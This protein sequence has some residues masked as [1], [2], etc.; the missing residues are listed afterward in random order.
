MIKV[1]NLVKNYGHA[2][3]LQ[4]VSF[5]VPAGQVLGFLGPNGAGKSTTMKIVTGYL[6]PTAGRVIVDG[7]DAA[8]EA[9]EVRRKVGYLPENNPLY[10]DMRVD[11]YLRFVGEIRGIKGADRRA[12]MDRVVEVCGLSLVYRKGIL[13]LSKGYRQRVGLAQ[14]MIHDPE[15]LILDEPTSGLDPNQIIEIREL[16]RSIAERED[17]T[18][19]LS[20][21]YLQEVE[22]T[23]DRI[24][25]ISQGEIV[26]DGSAEE[27]VSGYPSG[28]LEAQIV[29]P[30]EQVRAQLGEL[31]PDTKIRSGAGQE[32]ATSYEIPVGKH[33]DDRA[34]GA[35]F[36]LVVGNSWKLIELHREAASLETV[37]RALTSSDEAQ[38]SAPPTLPKDAAG[39]ALASGAG[40]EV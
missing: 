28:P 40:K 33:L 8:I 26:A 38:R 11:D 20:T 32:G 36:D 34:R 21:H 18:V 17:R 29:G 4:D 13:E 6:Y 3:A 25:I 30:E 39:E 1:E 9:L 22:A 24:M 19:I 12:A 10:A 2:I 23:C 7:H 16:I 15:I 31:F 37:F 27:L 5:E 35:I 14:A